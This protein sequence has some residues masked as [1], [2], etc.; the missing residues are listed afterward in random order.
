MFRRFRLAVL[1][2]PIV[3]GCFTVGPLMRP[4]CRTT[5]GCSPGS[6]RSAPASPPASSRPASMT[7]RNSVPSRCWWPSRPGPVSPRPSLNMPGCPAPFVNNVTQERVGG[8]TAPPVQP[9][10]DAD[11]LPGWQPRGPWSHD[12]R[13]LHQRGLADQHVR[14]AAGLL[15]RRADALERRQGCGSHL[16]QHRDRILGRDRCRVVSPRS[17]RPRLHH[18]LPGVRGELHPVR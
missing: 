3:A 16:P 6:W 18:A 13:S 7:A 1:V 14:A 8:S 9:A 17:G 10:G 12:A 2:L 15:P 11:P 5:T 4:I